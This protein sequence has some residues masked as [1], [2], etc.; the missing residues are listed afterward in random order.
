MYLF[1]DVAGNSDYR[2][3]RSRMLANNWIEQ[4]WRGNTPSTEYQSTVQVTI[5]SELDELLCSCQLIILRS[6]NTF[7]YKM[8]ARNWTR[9][10]I[11]IEITEHEAVIVKCTQLQTPSLIMVRS[12]D[13]CVVMQ[14]H[15]KE[16][17]KPS[18]LAHKSVNLEQLLKKSACVEQTVNKNGGLCGKGANFLPFCVYLHSNWIL[19]VSYRSAAV[20]VRGRHSNFSANCQIQLLDRERIQSQ[21]ITEFLQVKVSL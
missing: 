5:L 11:E 16:R 14:L 21:W 18:A 17:E 6:R 9:K 10:N 19:F 20:V 15:F 4:M 1:D 2:E 3:L 7:Q 8:V 13:L 12:R